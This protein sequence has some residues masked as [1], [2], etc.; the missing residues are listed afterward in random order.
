[1][2][3]LSNRSDGIVWWEELRDPESIQLDKAEWEKQKA[4][5]DHV[6]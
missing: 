6:Y 4:K 1:M 3:K 5:E 2:K